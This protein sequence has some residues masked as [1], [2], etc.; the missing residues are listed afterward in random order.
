MNEDTKGLLGQFACELLRD[1]RYIAL[2]TMFGQQMA[3]DM[4]NT[5]PQETKRREYLHAAYTGFSEFERLMQDFA[6]YYVDNYCEPEVR[7]ESID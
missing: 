1:D 4:L 3:V 7:V 5:Q 6:N 2:K